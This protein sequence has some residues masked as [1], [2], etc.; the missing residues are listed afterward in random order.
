MKRTDRIKLVDEMF[1]EAL[2]DTVLDG[3]E[4]RSLGEIAV[5]ACDNLSAGE[6]EEFAATVIITSLQLEIGRAA[7]VIQSLKRDA[8]K[9]LAVMAS[10]CDCATTKLHGGESEVCPVCQQQPLIE[11]HVDEATVQIERCNLSKP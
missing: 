1:P 6:E 11:K 3:E 2:A 5:E 7:K 4:K 9:F 10:N 8:E